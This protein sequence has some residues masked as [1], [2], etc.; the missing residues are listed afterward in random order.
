[1]K[2]NLLTEEEQSIMM[3][4]E[5][6]AQLSL[7]MASVADQSPTNQKIA[8]YIEK[9]YLQ[10]IFMTASEL[11]DAM[12]VSQGSVSRFFMMLGYRGY[13]EFLR[14]LQQVTL[15]RLTAPERLHY[16][17]PAGHHHRGSVLRPI[18]DSEIRN[19]D[20]MEKAMTGE[21]YEAMRAMIL[22]P[23]RLLLLSSRMSA[24]LLPYASYILGKMRDDV[25]VI[26]PETRAWE[27]LELQFPEKV[28][29]LAVAFPRYPRALIHKCA[30]LKKKG[31]RL[32]GLTDSRLSPLVN[33]VDHAVCVPVTTASLFDIYGTPLTFLNLLLR[34]AADRMPQ[35]TERINQIE[36]I[37]REEQV[38]VTK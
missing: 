13:N 38:Y 31:F 21:E 20:E 4:F 8:R 14:N 5:T 10:I 32:T 30:T 17:S 28:N 7:L 33:V 22:S 27:T 23:K 6:P 1:M 15:K 25:E 26:L 34:D 11:A 3:A 2:A 24:T 12:G 36:E 19:L 18:L 9:N 29:I 37:E 35:L 16:S